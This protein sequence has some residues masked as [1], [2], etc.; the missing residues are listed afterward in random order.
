[1]KVGFMF[2]KSDSEQNKTKKYLKLVYGKDYVNKKWQVEYRL[3]RKVLNIP[4]GNRK[5]T[6]VISYT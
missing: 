3:A 1:M 4:N 2:W 5:F 6:E